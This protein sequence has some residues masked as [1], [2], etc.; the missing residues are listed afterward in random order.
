MTSEEFK[1]R[2]AN[3][4]DLLQFFGLFSYI[5][6]RSLASIESRINHDFS[7]LP[8]IKVPHKEGYL[9]KK[10]AWAVRHVYNYHYYICSE[11]FLSYFA[12]KD[13]T[14]PQKVIALVGSTALCAEAET[15]I[16]NSFLLKTP[17]YSR[18][19]VAA[20]RQEMHEWIWAIRSNTNS[21]W[22]LF[23]PFLFP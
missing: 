6:K 11:G 20:N 19:F 23:I 8:Q 4:P 5:H 3:E 9:V 17:V 1:E 21:R 15:G 2:C 10:K 7:L 14:E 13:A 16:P 22:S 12:E 18:Y